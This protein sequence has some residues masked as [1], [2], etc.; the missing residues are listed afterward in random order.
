ML[1]VFRVRKFIRTIGNLH[2]AS[3]NDSDGLRKVWT[4]YK[5]EIVKV[6]EA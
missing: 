2:Y 1:G 6:L 5:T 3:L 4:N